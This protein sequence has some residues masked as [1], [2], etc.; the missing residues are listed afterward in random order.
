VKLP[1]LA[2]C[3]MVAAV[4]L[5]GCT[6][7]KPPPDSD[8]DGLTDLQE[9]VGWDI[10]VH[11]ANGTLVRHVTSDPDNPYTDGALPDRYKLILGLDPNARDTDGDGLTDCQEAYERNVTRCDDPAQR[12]ALVAQHD[13]GY[14]T[15]ANLADTDGDGL[16]DGLEVHGEPVAVA[17]TVR[18]VTTDPLV[19]DTDHDGLADG[20]EVRVGADPTVRDT[21]GDGCIDS[22]D[23]LP[24]VAERYSLQLLSLHVN[25]SARAV[26]LTA[27]L[28]G[29]VTD[30]VAN[31]T[32]GEADAANVHFASVRASGCNVSPLAPWVSVSVTANDASSGQPLD[33]ASGNPG[34]ALQAYWNVTEPASGGHASWDAFGASPSVLPLAWSGRDGSLLFRPLVATQAS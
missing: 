32:E 4:A 13:G 24:A 23:P 8:G 26:R 33:I 19:R 28:G 16:P 31:L 1:A 12:D 9:T 18:L 29:T 7:D 3:L 22:L 2:L 15:L 6:S 30:A 5:A 17:G 10:T 27:R 20:Q 11:A 34:G 14:G 25:G 21:D